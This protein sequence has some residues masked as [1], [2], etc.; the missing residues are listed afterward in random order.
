M[1]AEMSA[2]GTIYFTDVSVF[3]AR[4]TR[5]TLCVLACVAGSVVV[6]IS[7]IHLPSGEKFA[8]PSMNPLGTTLALMS[9]GDPPSMGI[10]MIQFETLSS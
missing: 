6:S 2:R 1:G 9:S 3:A 10:F 8:A 4:S 7:G 5:A